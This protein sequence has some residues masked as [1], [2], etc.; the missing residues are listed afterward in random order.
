[1][2]LFKLAL[3]VLNTVNNLASNAE[4][5][6]QKVENILN[7][8]DNIKNTAE[9]VLEKVQEYKDNNN[10]SQ[11]I[12]KMKTSIDNLDEKVEKLEGR[13]NEQKIQISDHY[14]IAVMYAIACKYNSI[15]YA[16]KN[17]YVAKLYDKYGVIDAN[18]NIIIPFEYDY[19]FDYSEEKFAACKQDKWGYIDINNNTVIDFVYSDAWS[20]SEG[21]APVGQIIDEKEL[22]GYIDS[23][24]NYIISPQYG[25]AESF[26]KNGLACVG[27]ID[28]WGDA[29]KGVI[30]KQNF[31]IVNC[32][33]AT[34][35]ITENYIMYRKESFHSPK[36]LDLN[37]NPID[38]NVPEEETPKDKIIPY[39]NEQ[40]KYGYYIHTDNGDFCKIEPIFDD[41]THIN[42]FGYAIVKRDGLYGLIKFDGSEV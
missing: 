8:A 29:R 31:T 7:T 17:M 13:S 1:M 5:V 6:S 12:D 23:N 19:I 33:N 22:Y 28:T 25:Y 20:F 26:H 16:G 11:L 4:D 24:G 21:L 10:P 36:Y 30:N 41:A 34:I 32:K 40:L 37:G 3:G 9:V 18:E 39:F 38:M 2:G 14:K 27:F 42:K 35:K 15:H